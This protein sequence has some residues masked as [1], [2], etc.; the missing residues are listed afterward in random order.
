MTQPLL[1]LL[2]EPAE[3][4]ARLGDPA[5]A[6]I[7]LSQPALHARSHVPGAVHLDYARIIAPRPP[8]AAVLPEPQQLAEAL[9]SIG[10]TPDK[11]VVAYDDEGNGRAARFLWTLEVIGHARLSILNGGIRAWLA[12]QRPVESGVKPV[13]ATSYPVQISRNA[14]AD[15][16]YI[17][18]HLR[19]PNVVLLDARSPDEYS[20]KVKR[21][22]RAG[23]IPG[24][25]NFQWTDAMDAMRQ[26]RLKNAADIKRTLEGL[27]ITPDK[28]IVTYCQTHH[29][30]AH[31]YFVLKTLGYPRVRAYP[32]S[33]SEWGSLPDTPI[34]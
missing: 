18:A 23:H 11:Q 10:L 32:G 14:I 13:S 12:E 6:I 27:G 22:A 21:S 19:D 15:K 34:E 25:V 2:V 8:A 24:A 31:T 33:W 16:E 4:A 26:T 1:P 9:G 20:G 28:E 30:S 3:L 17:L 7:D 29:R 5:L